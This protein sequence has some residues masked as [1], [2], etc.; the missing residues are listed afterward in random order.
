MLMLWQRNGHRYW[1]LPE[2]IR[3]QSSGGGDGAVET[4][5]ITIEAY[6]SYV[7]HHV[8]QYRPILRSPVHQIPRGHSQAVY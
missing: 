8:P 1:S 2:D 3:P 5:E 6:S 4:V 7:L